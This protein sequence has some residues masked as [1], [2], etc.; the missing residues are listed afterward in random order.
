M[1]VLVSVVTLSSIQW[2]LMGFIEA[3]TIGITTTIVG[4]VILG[5]SLLKGPHSVIKETRHILP[6][7]SGENMDAETLE[8]VCTTI[9][10]INGIFYLILGFIIQLLSVFNI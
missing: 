6:S 2:G 1:W 3:Q 7:M 5:L 10:G 8:Y 9:D 4:S